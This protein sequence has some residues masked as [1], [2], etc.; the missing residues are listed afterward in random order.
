M[1]VWSHFSESTVCDSK[2]S[3]WYFCVV[4]VFL[5]WIPKLRSKHFIPDYVQQQNLEETVD[6]L[7]DFDDSVV[8]AD[9]CHFFSLCDTSFGWKRLLTSLRAVI[10]PRSSNLRIFLQ[11]YQ[12]RLYQRQSEPFTPKCFQHRFPKNQTVL[13]GKRRIRKRR[14]A[15]TY[16]G[17]TFCRFN[18]TFSPGFFFN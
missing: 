16:Q 17:R 5:F 10:D 7:R 11:L 3:E 2:V 13:T 1:I 6:L 8:H 18:S 15:T 12:T 4:V 9:Q 14:L